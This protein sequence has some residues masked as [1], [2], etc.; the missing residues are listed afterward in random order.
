MLFSFDF[1]VS[2]RATRLPSER[3]LNAQ[4]ALEEAGIEPEAPTRLTSA[5]EARAALEAW[6]L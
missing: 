3:G 2:D 4:E 6:R 1:D 5:L